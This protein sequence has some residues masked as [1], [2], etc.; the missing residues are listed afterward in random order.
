MS[1]LCAGRARFFA[2]TPSPSPTRWERGVGAHGGAPCSAF[3]LSRPA[4]EG[5]TARLPVHAHAG[6]IAPAAAIL[7]RTDVPLSYQSQGQSLQLP[8]SCRF[9][10]L[11][12]GNRVGRVGSVPPACRGNLKEGVLVYPYFCELWLGDW[13]KTN[14][15]PIVHKCPLRRFPL[16]RKGN[17]AGVRFPLLARGT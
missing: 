16:L 9:P 7:C 11:R 10:P 2:L 1:S 8:P 12:E 4:G 13:Y 14:R 17:R 3:P 6:K 15:Q 5:N